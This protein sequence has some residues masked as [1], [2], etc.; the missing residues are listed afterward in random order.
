MLVLVHVHVHVQCTAHV[1]EQICAK[2]QNPIAGTMT[3]SNRDAYLQLKIIAAKA[4]MHSNSETPHVVAE[5]VNKLVGW[6]CVRS[7]GSMNFRHV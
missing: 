2:T 5:W 3:Q 1:H 6:D 7:A 4:M